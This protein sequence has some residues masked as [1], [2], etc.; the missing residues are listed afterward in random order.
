[1]GRG[2]IFCTKRKSNLKL[3]ELRSY[4][5]E[6][7]G[8]L[9]ATTIGLA[10]KFLGGH[11]T[12]P[13]VLF[14]L[15]IG[16]CFHFSYGDKKVKDGIDFTADFLLKLAVGLLG[17]R[18]TFSSLQNIGF[19][20]IIVIVF[21]VF[22]T[23]S[24]GIILA[25][26]FGKEKDFGILSGGATAICGVSAAVAICSLMPKSKHR[27]R[28]MA[29]VIVGVTILS[30]LSMIFYPIL[31]K[32]FGMTDVAA[33]FVL[34]A[35]IHD[36]AQV[37]G[38]GYSI[39]NDAGITATFIKMVRVSLLP[40]II[41]ALLIRSNQSKTKNIK[42]P[43]FLILF[44]VM[45]ISKNLFAIPEFIDS[46]VEFISSWLLIVSIAAIG[47][48]TSLASVTSVSYVYGAILIL[49]TVFLLSISLVSIN[50]INIF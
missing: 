46:S 42:L 26:S 33:G 21:T 10:S 18:L 20:A 7:R 8:I 45:A 12:V 39:S 36:V 32:S 24:F 6:F 4:R 50:L 30:T 3:F 41:I 22:L 2:F 40:L 9:L 38:A 16:L 14:A 31:F 35:S 43:W 11:Y 34:G 37:V 13:S 25:K 23:I 19:S 29:I 1:M 47:V 27:N 15:L 44:F 49:E 17:F 48:R 5:N 28:D